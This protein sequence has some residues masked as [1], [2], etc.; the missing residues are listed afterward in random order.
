MKI[1]MLFYRN[2]KQD[3]RQI[4]ASVPLKSLIID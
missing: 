2:R 1:N 4:A 3:E